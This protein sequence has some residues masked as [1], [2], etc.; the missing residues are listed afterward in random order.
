MKNVKKSIGL[1][2]LVALAIGAVIVD[3]IIKSDCSLF[4]E[5]NRIL[6]TLVTVISGF[7]VTSYLLFL[8]TYKDRYPLK[9]NENRYLSVM[10]YDI[11]YIIYCIIYGCFIIIKNGG[12]VEN[13]WY[14]AS[15]LY[16]I[17]IILKHVYD[18]NKTMMVNTYVDDFCDNISQ[19][20]ENREN[21]V[22]KG[23]F[24]DLR[25]VLDECVVKEEYLVVQNIAIKSGEIFRGFL[26]NSISLICEGN[27]KEDIDDSFDRI[28]D[29]GIYQLELCKDINSELLIKDIVVQQS[30]NLEFCVEW[31]LFEWFKKYIKKINILTFCEQKDGNDKMVFLTYNIYTNILE[32]LVEKESEEWVIYLL[33][34]LFSMA[35]SLNFIASNSNLKYFAALVTYGLVN[36]EN[37]NVKNYIFNVFNK[38]TGLACKISNGLNDIKAYYAVYFDK[39]RS[40]K[41]DIIQFLDMIFKYAQDCANDVGWIEF[42]FYCIKEIMESDLSAEIDINK[43]H[44]KLIIEVIEMKEQYHGFMFMPQYNKMILDKQ[45]SRSEYE[46]IYHDIRYLFNKTIVNDNL[47]M[48][49]ILL[50]KVSECIV[51]TQINHKELQLD[52]LN[53]FI[54]LVERT[55]R[56][57]NKQYLEVVFIELEDDLN[58]LDKKR[59][60]SKDFGDKIITE[61]SDIARY[62]DSDSHIVVLQVIEVFSNFL[63]ENKELC[64]VSNYLDRKE[65]LYKG[66]FNIA[67][68]CIENNFEEGVRRCSN[69]IGWFSIYSIRQGN[70]KHTKYLITLA[71]EMLDISI[72]M[73]ISTKTQTF[74][75][76]LFV[77]VGMFCCKENANLVYLELILSAIND[78]DP[79]LVYTA[80][81]IRTYE[82]DMWDDLLEKNTQKLATKFKKVYDESKK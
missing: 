20:I 60:I 56:L 42:K 1:I 37:A 39:V 29:I 41:K 2:G 18:T 63:K 22:K 67:T 24:K 23:V 57:S 53:I 19:R 66:I 31:D 13:A 28:V 36:C 8:Q 80:I 26:K 69:A 43:Y 33:D 12:L 52:L 6:F 15:S 30:K 5:I 58:E 77:T 78:V 38:L 65:K 4:N 17:F 68:S 9:L 7:W 72:D 55:K 74:L 79:N 10:K 47:D 45:Y 50:N 46:N 3:L 34:N 61:L 21:S 14:V 59:A 48:F 32:R 16:T 25:Y 70:G 27:N 64:F 35:A 54:W 73:N 49:F 51:N 44:N 62:A 82:N 11:A 40:N 76:T 71:K 81:K 75:L